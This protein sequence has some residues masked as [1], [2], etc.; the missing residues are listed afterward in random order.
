MM[1]LR[2]L[3]EKARDADL[4]RELID[5]VAERLIELEAGT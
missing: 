1:S 4:L 2:N 3:L 5:V